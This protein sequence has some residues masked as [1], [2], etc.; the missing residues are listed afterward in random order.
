VANA[1][2]RD[3]DHPQLRCTRCAATITDARG[4]AVVWG[5]GDNRPDR[6]LCGRCATRPDERRGEPLDRYLRDLLATRGVGET[7]AA[8]EALNA[9]RPDLVIVTH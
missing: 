2:P 6:V 7:L 8:L 5:H 9:L 3:L 1:S 4:A